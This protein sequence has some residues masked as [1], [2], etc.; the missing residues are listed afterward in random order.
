MTTAL[1]YCVR[2]AETLSPVGLLENFLAPPASFGPVPFWWWTGDPLNRERIR[3]QLD[4]LVSKGVRNALVSYNHLSDGGIDP[5]DPPAFS[6]AWWEL[7]RWTLD[8]CR[9]RG[10]Q[11]GIQ[12][13]C[14]IGPLLQD[15]GKATPEMAGAG[16]L[17][18]RHQCLQEGDA[19]EFAC[20][21]T[22]PLVA[23]WA[24]PLENGKPG[25][26]R[27][28]DLLCRLQGGRLCWMAP[29]GEWLLSV[30][31]LKPNPFDPAHP[32]S[33]RLL[34]EN[35][36]EPFVRNCPGHV[37]RTLTVFFQD[38]LDFGS[39][40]PLWSAS[41]PEAFAREHGYD[42][43]PYLPALWHDLGP[44][45]VKLRLDYS[46]TIVR[47]IEQ[48]YFVPVFQ[49]HEGHGTLLANDNC[50]RGGIEAGRAVYGDYFRTMRWYHGPGCD[51]PNLNAPR[52][53]KGLKVNSSIAHLYRRPKVWS[54]CFHSS[55]WG[56]APA[57]ILPALDENFL[58][59]ATAISLHGLYYSTHGSWWEWAS[60]DFHFRQPYWVHSGILNDYISRLSFL[61]S[62]GSHVCD[63]AIL[64]P[65]AAL[66]GGLNPRCKDSS[67][68][69]FSEAQA[70]NGHTE[71]DAAE[72]DAFVIGN[73]LVQAGIDFDFVDFESMERAK[74]DQG[75]LGIRDESY[76]VLILPQ[77]SSIRFSTL[78]KARDFYRAGGVVIAL[79]CLPVASERHGSQ[80]PELA[81]MKTEIFGAE[82]GG[83]EF[84]SHRD[85]NG[86][87]GFFLP[88]DPA[89]LVEVI[90]GNID[91]DFSTAGPRLQVLH[92][93]SD[94]HDIFFVRNP[95]SV[96][97]STEARFRAHGL[98]ERWNAID[99]KIASLFAKSSDD[100]GTLLDV[101]LEA[102]EAQLI[103]FTEA[104]T[105]SGE[106]SSSAPLKEE[107][108]ALGGH[109]E[110]T[111]QPTMDNRFGD[112]RHPANQGFIGV[113]ARQFR[114]AQ[115][116]P[117]TEGCHRSDYNDSQWPLTTSSF[118]KRFWR[119]G[120]LP[121]DSDIRELRRKLA[122]TDALDPLVPVIIDGISYHWL[123]YEF[124]LRWGIENDPFL[125]DWASGPHGLK[126]SVPDEFIDLHCDCAGSRWLLWTTIQAKN[127]GPVPILMG[128]RAAYRAWV[129][130]SAVLDQP[131]SLPP[132]RHPRWNLPHYDS[133]PREAAIVLRRGA[134]PVLLEFLQPE[135][136]R[137]RAYIA[138]DPPA[139]SS[140]LALRW[141]QNPNGPQFNCEPRQPATA[142][143]FRF[144]AP[145]GLAKLQVVTRSD[146]HVWAD[147]S[148]LARE[149][150]VPRSDGCIISN[151]SV[152]QPSPD[153]A[154]VAIRIENAPPGSFGG[155]CLPEPV[156][157]ECIAGR[158][159]LT[160][161]KHIGLETYS[162]LGIYRQSFRLT[163]EQA[164]SVRL[165]LDLG[166]VAAT[167]SIRINGADAGTLLR[168]PWRVDIGAHI[169]PGE[170]RLEIT[171]ANTLANHYSVGIPTP[172]ALSNQQRSGLLG[173]V[174]LHRS[175]HH[176]TP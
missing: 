27:A 175:S 108:I 100:A 28:V 11:L 1:P 86:G 84:T 67:A 150:I 160:D 66:E 93:R 101:A 129:N 59:G 64:Y 124:S 95:A 72:R 76:R 12:D 128:S 165:C 81:A 174:R 38:E 18:E 176:H 169:R 113:E 125:I 170:N 143:W 87:V 110:F 153:S 91:R 104:V 23:V 78:L 94:S 156:T 75:C 123:P 111:L 121:R 146:A 109:W 21:P 164:A 56:T 136:Q 132:G 8:E 105:A 130:G 166:D 145:P 29:K 103:V 63:V 144:T 65:I 22:Q 49:W 88:E 35:L 39:R 17:L 89:R 10:M 122:N 171:V 172:Y 80:D 159:R 51:D 134:N 149:S 44:R 154:I 32:G 162:G 161:W 52:A 115:E 168:P 40:M 157:M 41:L 14:I 30:V 68:V 163:E 152:Q 127:S 98:V 135:G 140:E 45:T 43:L 106:A 133:T 20:D 155:D 102:N 24:F 2:K 131:T 4:Q 99:G 7:F 107:E 34:I 137:V 97:V 142:Q 69:P 92:R 42:I 61:L 77:M 147:G 148:S 96:P 151:W 57:H 46:Q 3:W 138:V 48:H 117:A 119:L 25:P 118:G 73:A 19:Y 62:Q 33:G 82:S 26:T 58:Y 6:E 116:S 120:P 83:N 5:G 90:T 15:I 37:G 126:P 167:A 74:A 173:P 50:G 71:L 31:T 55:G 53:F 112:F 139:P 9:A 158:I 85:I 47:L 70:G 16:Q 13:Y 36:Y 60:P 141:F 54:E 114:Y 79:G